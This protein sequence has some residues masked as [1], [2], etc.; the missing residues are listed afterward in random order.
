MKNWLVQVKTL[1]SL[2]ELTVPQNED[3]SSQS[4]VWQACR[5]QALELEAG[6]STDLPWENPSEDVWGKTVKAEWLGEEHRVEGPVN[7]SPAQS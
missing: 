2:E 1:A 3:V 7:R 6:N 5:G 4:E